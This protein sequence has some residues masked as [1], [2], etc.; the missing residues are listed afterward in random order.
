V[1]IQQVLTDNGSRY[2][3]Q[4][5][6]DTCRQLAIT[7]KR[8]RPYRPQ[9]NGKVERFNRTLVEGW[10]Y[11]RLYASEHARRLPSD[12]GCTGITATGPT[13]RLE[14]VHRSPAAPTPVPYT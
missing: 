2:R 11:R 3:S 12:P 6:R 13:A 8:T 4:L 1:V 5:W 9:T 14:V 10:A 7:P